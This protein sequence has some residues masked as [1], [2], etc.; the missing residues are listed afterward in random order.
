[1][2]SDIEERFLYSS[3]YICTT[4]LESI[5]FSTLQ[6]PVR[7]KRQTYFAF[8]PTEFNTHHQGRPVV[9][10]E[11]VQVDLLHIGKHAVEAIWSYLHFPRPE[12]TSRS[13]FS[14]HSPRTA[15]CS[16]R[17]PWNRFSTNWARFGREHSHEK[18]LQHKVLFEYICGVFMSEICRRLEF[19]LKFLF[20][21]LCSFRLV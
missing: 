3:I 13:F 10:C 4:S 7:P 8:A 2:R 21:T 19:L 12:Q 11:A 18:W 15:L 16:Q 9:N 14:S 1:M 5:L 17:A 6:V 20:N